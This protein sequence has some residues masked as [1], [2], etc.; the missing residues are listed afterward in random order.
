MVS[1][2]D[3]IPILETTQDI[4]SVGGW[5]IEKAMQTIA[6]WKK[7]NPNFKQIHVNVSTVQFRVPRF[8]EYVFDT[9]QKYNLPGSAL[10]LELTESCRVKSTEEFAELFEEFKRHGVMTALDDFGTGYASLIVLCD[11]PVDILKLDLQLTQNFV[12][13]PQHRAILKL[14]ADLCKNGKIR[15]CAEGVETEE[16]LALMKNAGAE[17][18]QGYFFSKP[19]PAAEFRK[20]YI[21][22]V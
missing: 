21:E 5:V 9:L 10:V 15:L 4:V 17:L 14:V 7:I 3:F 1:P 8:K 16:S 6:E 2:M 11:I 13:Y 22:K 19:L 12:K 18:I 20:K